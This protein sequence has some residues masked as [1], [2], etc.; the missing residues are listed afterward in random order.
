M[1]NAVRALKCLG[2]RVDVVKSGPHDRHAGFIPNG[3]SKRPVIHSA[4]HDHHVVS[5]TSTIN[6]QMATYEPG[7]ARDPNTHCS[8]IAASTLH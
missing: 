8:T 1:G 7:A 3:L 5:V 6:G 2:E 4:S